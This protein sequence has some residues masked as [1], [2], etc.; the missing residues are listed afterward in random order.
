MYYLPIRQDKPVCPFFIFHKHLDSIANLGVAN[1]L[2]IYPYF[3]DVLQ[4]VSVTKANDV[5][6]LTPLRWKEIFAQKTMR[7][8]LD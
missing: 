7:S 8:D 6:D 3:V 1:H 4:R 5:A 2:N